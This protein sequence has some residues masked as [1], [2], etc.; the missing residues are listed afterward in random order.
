M[1]EQLAQE[2]WVCRARLFVERATGAAGDEVRHA[3]L[4]VRLIARASTGV[5][6]ED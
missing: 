5:V 4:P 3:I 1:A 2:G 6:A